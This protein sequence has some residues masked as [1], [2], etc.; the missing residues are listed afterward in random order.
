M[1]DGK[2]DKT[3]RAEQSRRLPPCA[4]DEGGCGNGARKARQD[5]ARQSGY[6]SANLVFRALHQNSA[7]GPGKC[8]VSVR[9]RSSPICRH[10]EYFVCAYACVDADADAAMVCVCVLWYDRPSNLEGCGGSKWMLCVML[11]GG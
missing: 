11:H 8:G 9:R 2:L 1:K 10:S 5:K 6:F 7:C 3:A 4:T